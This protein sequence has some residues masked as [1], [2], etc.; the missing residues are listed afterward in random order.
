MLCTPYR[1]HTRDPSSEVLFVTKAWDCTTRMEYRIGRNSP[2]CTRPAKRFNRLFS[3][4][5][6]LVSHTPCKKTMHGRCARWRSGAECLV[7]PALA[8]RHAVDVK[9][10]FRFRP[11]NLGQLKDQKILF[12]SIYARRQCE[13]TRLGHTTFKAPVHYP[14]RQNCQVAS[15]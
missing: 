9:T 3:K 5:R 1:L 13:A 10:D 15:K 2:L 7:R 12:L 4:R 8:D 14:T 11:L 6:R